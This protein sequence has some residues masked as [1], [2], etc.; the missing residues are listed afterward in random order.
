[1][2]SR[3]AAVDGEINALK[4]WLEAR[5][6]WI[7]SE[8]VRPPI[9]SV[10]SGRL[11]TEL[12]VTL[13]NPNESGTIFYTLDGS[14]PWVPEVS[15]DSIPTITLIQEN[16]AKNILVPSGPV[17]DAWKGGDEFDDSAW[18][19]V[20]TRG[21]FGGVGY[22]L[23]GDYGS[24]ISFDLQSQMLATSRG[25]R[26]SCYVRIPFILPG[27]ADL[28]NTLTLQIRYDDGFVAYLNGVEVARSGLAGE[29]VWHSKADNEHS[30]MILQDVDITDFKDQLVNG[31]NV[32]A[33]HGLNVSDTSS[34]F[35]NLAEIIEDI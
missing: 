31:V 3:I 12:T 10:T 7:D 33:I 9:L 25:G 8:F 11:N 30:G 21:G 15:D 13:E 5:A 20:K 19:L 18:T 16:A 27:T 1:M 26:T 35:L 24:M 23:S 29:P 17:D 32:L 14:D 34:D 28:H 22:D 4:D 2:Q 6:L